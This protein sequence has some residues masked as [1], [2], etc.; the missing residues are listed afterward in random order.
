MPPRKQ[1]TPTPKPRLE[2]P[3]PRLF[4]IYVAL[5]LLGGVIAGGTNNIV[6]T[7]AGVPAAETLATRNPG[8]HRVPRPANAIWVRSACSNP[9]GIDSCVQLLP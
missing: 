5:G 3:T 1:Q 8:L 6:K 9:A 2:P 4:L 7:S